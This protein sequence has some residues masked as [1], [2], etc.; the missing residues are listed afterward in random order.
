MVLWSI[1]ESSAGMA[2]S[3]SPGRFTRALSCLLYT[4]RLDRN[5]S[6]RFGSHSYAAEELIAELGSAF[7][8]ADLGVT[9]EPR[10]DHAS[11]IQ[12][13]LTVLKSDKRAIFT[14]AAHAERAAAFLHGLQ[15]KAEIADEPGAESA[16]AQATTAQPN[17]VPS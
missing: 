3:S 5:L 7:L 12:N 6:G 17:Y 14:A 4:S 2:T 10:E 9:P 8:S 11:Y 1:A 16:M 15:P 13:W